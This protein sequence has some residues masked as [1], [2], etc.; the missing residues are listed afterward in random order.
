[1]IEAR[2]RT[3]AKKAES[4]ASEQDEPPLRPMRGD[5]ISGSHQQNNNQELRSI[6]IDTLRSI[7][8]ESHPAVPLF[9]GL[10]PNS[11]QPSAQ[12]AAKA[13]EASNEQPT[14]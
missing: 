1:L 2:A 5:K 9:A 12:E 4:S 14:G 3:R 6:L 8:D 7:R 10:Q 11:S 13:N